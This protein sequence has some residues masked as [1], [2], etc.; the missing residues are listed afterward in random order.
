MG[1]VARAAPEWVFDFGVRPPA[2]VPWHRA[3]RSRIEV[4]WPVG[5][6]GEPSTPSYEEMLANWWKFGF[7]V[8]VRGGLFGESDRAPDVP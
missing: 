6:S 1:V 4:P 7:V 2:Q 8:E 3:T 5:F